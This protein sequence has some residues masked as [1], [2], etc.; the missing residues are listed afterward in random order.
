MTIR[1]KK[2]EDEVL[3]SMGLINQAESTEENKA[4]GLVIVYSGI[5]PGTQT[6]YNDS[7]PGIMYQGAFPAPIHFHGIGK[8]YIP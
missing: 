4:K 1:Q 6:P 8:A 2:T 5:K 7:N 3:V